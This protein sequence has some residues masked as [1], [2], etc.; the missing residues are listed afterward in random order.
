MIL[1]A[2]KLYFLKIKKGPEITKKNYTVSY[3]KFFGNMYGG[4]DFANTREEV[5]RFT[6]RALQKMSEY[7]LI[8]GRFPEEPTFNNIDLKHVNID[9]IVTKAAVLDL[10][11]EKGWIERTIEEK[12]L[13]KQVKK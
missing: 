6:T 7:D 3:D 1:I 12:I 2:K 5:L 10:F 9:K 8:L 13:N 11:L 4:C